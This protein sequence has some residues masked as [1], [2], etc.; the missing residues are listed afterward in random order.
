MF[1]LGKIS[2]ILLALAGIAAAAGAYNDTTS[3]WEKQANTT[4]QFKAYAGTTRIT[5]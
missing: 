1:M 4:L 5:R 3:F 2:L